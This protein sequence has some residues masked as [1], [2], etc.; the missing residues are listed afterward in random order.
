MTKTLWLMA[1]FL[2][3]GLFI[4]LAEAPLA[5]LRIPSS[6]LV[7]DHPNTQVLAGADLYYNHCAVCHGDTLGGLAEA[8]TAFP[9][10]KQN[11]ERCHRRNNPKVMDMSQM[12]WRNAFSIGDAPALG[13]HH[14]TDALQA[15]NNGAALYHYISATMPRPFPNSLEPEEYL[16]I[17]AFLLAVNGADINAAMLEL[18]NLTDFILPSPSMYSLFWNCW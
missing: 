4:A 11:C 7:V 16:A 14:Q 10:E 9:L 1:F 5:E 15:L 8:R 17:S 12:T 18:D 13:R 3:A 6:S 2:A